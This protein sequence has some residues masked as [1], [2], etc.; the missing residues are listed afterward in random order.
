MPKHSLI[1][2]SRRALCF[3]R[4][5]CV[6]ATAAGAVVVVVIVLVLS[7]LTLTSTIAVA[8]QAATAIAALAALAGNDRVRPSSCGRAAATCQ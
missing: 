8:A 1:A 7:G 5:A 3:S 6:P 4:Q 2:R